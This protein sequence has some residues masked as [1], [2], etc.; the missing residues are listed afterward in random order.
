MGII[1]TADTKAKASL[2][3][4]REISSFMFEQEYGEL[5]GQ[6]KAI[7]ALN[8]AKKALADVMKKNK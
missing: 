8:A 6:D 2:K 7:K 1:I 4:Y 3:L 5:R